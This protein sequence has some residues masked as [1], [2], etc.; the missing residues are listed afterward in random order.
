MRDEMI[1]QMELRDAEF[2]GRIEAIEDCAITAE[3][4]GSPEIAHA[5]RMLS[6]RAVDKKLGANRAA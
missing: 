1:R 4:N 3:R 5:I 6:Q 2:I